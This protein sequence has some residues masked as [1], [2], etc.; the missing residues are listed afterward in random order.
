MHPLAVWTLLGKNTGGMSWGDGP[1]HRDSELL[2]G[3]A[4]HRSRGELIALH[5]DGVI[6]WGSAINRDNRHA[7]R[8][9]RTLRQV[10]SREL[11]HEL[12]HDS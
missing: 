9:P 2:T 8:P 3:W 4:R 10:T 12:S 7:P 11:S 1:N 5:S 6:W